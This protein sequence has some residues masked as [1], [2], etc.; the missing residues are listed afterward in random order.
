MIFHIHEY[1]RISDPTHSHYDVNGIEVMTA[2]C[3]CK[4]CGKTKQR[5]FVGHIIGQLGR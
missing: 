1:E 5:K 4:I 3:K 2:L